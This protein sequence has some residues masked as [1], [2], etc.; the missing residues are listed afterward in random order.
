M[1]GFAAFAS[2]YKEALQRQQGEE[3]Q[4]Q[5]AGGKEAGGVV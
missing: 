1:D 3:D 5:T 4:G 2:R